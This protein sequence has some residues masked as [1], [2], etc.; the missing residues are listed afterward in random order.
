MDIHNIKPLRILQD[1]FRD[2]GGKKKGLE[3]FRSWRPK[4]NIVEK[5]T[6]NVVS[7]FLKFPCMI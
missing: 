2:R 4:E 5:P 1:P 7:A 3:S 6:F